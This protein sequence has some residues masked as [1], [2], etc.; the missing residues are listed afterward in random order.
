[1]NM[2]SRH[3]RSQASAERPRTGYFGL[4]SGISSFFSGLAKQ[5]REIRNRERIR[6]G[7][8][9]D[10]LMTGSASS[11]DATTLVGQLTKRLRLD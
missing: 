9:R 8:I 3:Y 7:L 11:P 10:H 4:G 6:M 1:M 5:E 2:E